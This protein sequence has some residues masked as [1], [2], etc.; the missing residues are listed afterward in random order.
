MS[1][2]ESSDEEEE[3]PS[4][5]SGKDAREQVKID[6]RRIARDLGEQELADDDVLEDYSVLYESP[7]DSVNEVAELQNALMSLAS[8][9]ANAYIEAL[10]T[11][12]REELIAAFETSKEVFS[13][14]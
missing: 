12:L 7:L 11:P 8:G 3:R 14:K 2:G 6:L 5:F 13:G 9:R 4:P 10:E 1:D